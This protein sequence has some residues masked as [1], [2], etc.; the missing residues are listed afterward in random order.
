ML[1]D[2]SR[3]PLLV[4]NTHLFIATSDM[5]V[6]QPN[7]W[8]PIQTTN[9]LYELLLTSGD[10]RKKNHDLAPKL[11]AYAL[12]RFSYAT[13]NVATILCLQLSYILRSQAGC[14]TVTT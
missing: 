2:L 4:I 14:N 9:R 12:T 6:S 11:A 8:K 7:H 13:T 10:W 1:S 3:S 5:E